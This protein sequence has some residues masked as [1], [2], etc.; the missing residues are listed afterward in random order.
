M[1]RVP[2]LFV[3][4]TEGY[5]GKTAVCLGLALKMR[6]KGYK[7]GYFRPIGLEMIRTPNGK[8]IDED[9]ILMNEVLEL[10]LP[11][12]TI[13]P[14]TLRS[15]FLEECSKVEPKIYLERIERAY[16]KASEGKD[17]L[18]I[19][20]LNRV[21]DC[22]FMELSA[23]ILAKKFE[24]KVLI[25]SRAA[26]D[27]VVDLILRDKKCIQA[28]GA[29]CIGTI[30]N[31]VPRQILEKVKEIAVSILEKHNVKVWGVIP[32]DVRLTAPTVREI[33]EKLGG[34][35]LVREDKLDNLIED[36]LVGAMTAESS[37]KY[38]RR[39]VNK[40]VI[41][42]GDRADLALAALETSMSVLILTG[43]L[44]PSVKVLVRAE[45]Q[46]VPVLLVPYDTYT[47]VQYLSKIAG[48]IKPR[49]TK[50]I[51]LTKQFIETYVNWEGILKTV[52]PNL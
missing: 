10:K 11:Q 47:T 27:T 50:K 3:V 39:T 36:F 13:V 41:T 26:T 14:L 51:E 2:S 28:E 37:L 48:R 49:D 8:P 21:E 40:A 22:T 45:E 29:P 33:H 25:V 31:Y 19:E 15:R 42:G 52:L 32:E 43:N 17:I 4:S 9:A 38:F 5:A 18:I 6:E 23:P 46:G 35:I 44:Y 1:A 30:L 34:E 24:S 12:E 16:A 7:V 20:G